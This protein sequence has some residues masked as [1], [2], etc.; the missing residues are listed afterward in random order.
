[1]YS[2]NYVNC[3]ACG[4]EIPSRYAVIGPDKWVY[5]GE[6]FDETFT[7]CDICNQFVGVNTSYEIEDGETV[8][9]ECLEMAADLTSQP[10]TI[11]EY[12]HGIQQ[13]RAGINPR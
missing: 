4:K 2:E 11:E 7:V 8:C 3:D 9:S 1:M 10:L 6:C 12:Y 5:C 13:P